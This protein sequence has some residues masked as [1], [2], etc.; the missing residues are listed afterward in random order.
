MV[1]GAVL[2][3]SAFSTTQMLIARI[4]SGIG[5]GLNT[6]TAPVWQAETSKASM[7]GKLVVLELVL[8][9]A[10]FSLSNWVNYGFTYTTGQIQ[11]RFPIALQLLF[12]MVLFATVPW[13]PESPRWLVNKGRVAEAEKII[14]DLEDLDVDDPWVLTQSKEVQFAANEERENS[15]PFK[16]LLRGRTGKGK[17]T[18]VLRRLLLGM[19]AQA[20]QQLAGINVTSYYLPTVLEQS[21]GLR[22]KMPTLIAACNSVSY[23][24]FGSIALL[25]VESLGRRIL[26]IT[27]SAGQGFCYLIITILLSQVPAGGASNSTQQSCASASIAFFFLYYVFFGFGFQGVPWLVSLKHY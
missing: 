8:N 5:N 25:F 20:L 15:V 22:G 24:F 3:I 26:L 2:Q 1:V 11:W 23:L 21:V 6:A 17:G 9:I 7:R 18:C 16:D 12:I 13:L 19:S 27:A 14:A 4:I 10:G